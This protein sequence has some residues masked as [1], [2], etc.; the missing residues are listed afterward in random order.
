MT[1]LQIDFPYTGPTGDQMANAFK[2]LAASI[3]TEDGL[4]WKIWTENAQ[5]GEAGGIYLFQDRE[6]AERYAAMH[7]ERL[8]GFGIQEI[9]ARLFEINEPLSKICRAPL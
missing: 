2:E 4:V 3:S 7:T 1:L 9:R 5:T 6:N 8:N